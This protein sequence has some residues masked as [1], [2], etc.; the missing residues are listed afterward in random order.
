MDSYFFVA[1]NISYLFETWKNR[2]VLFD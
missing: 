1:L 2:P